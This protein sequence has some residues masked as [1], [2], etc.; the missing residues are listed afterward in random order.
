MNLANLGSFH[1]LLSLEHL[2]KEKVKIY[3]APVHKDDAFPCA[4]IFFA[5]LLW[6]S[7]NRSDQNSLTNIM[8]YK[9]C[10]CKIQS[11]GP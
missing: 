2:A 4:W 6:T 7:C 11:S 5:F 1:V 9:G 3:K 8:Q 10:T